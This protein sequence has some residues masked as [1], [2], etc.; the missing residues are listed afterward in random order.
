MARY[1]AA[2]TNSP[3]VVLHEGCRGLAGCKAQGG[4]R[5]IGALTIEYITKPTWAASRVLLHMKAA[6]YAILR[7]AKKPP[8]LSAAG[9]FWIELITCTKEA[10]LSVE[11]GNNDN[12]W[13][14]AKQLWVASII[15]Q[16]SLQ[17]CCMTDIEGA[18]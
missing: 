14:A 18:A 7:Y 10:A 11:G 13:G 15:L 1:Q 4:A 16:G 3:V 17:L 2:T 5:S 12:G 9:A 6:A 8:G